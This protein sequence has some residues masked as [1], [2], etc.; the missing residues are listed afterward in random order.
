MMDL[1]GRKPGEL[2]FRRI[3]GLWLDWLIN[4]PRL[5]HSRWSGLFQVSTYLG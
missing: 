3:P 2:N 1:T 4:D 5:T